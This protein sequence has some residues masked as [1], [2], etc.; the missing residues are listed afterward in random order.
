MKFVAIIPARKGSKGIKNKNFK[1]FNNKPLI[2]WTI[3]A[4]KKSNFIDKIIVST[5]SK[6]IQNFSIS[7]KVD[8]PFLRPKK[9]ST[10]TAKAKDV[11]FHAI[12]FL[13][14]K[15]DYKPD[16]VIY[17]QPTSPLREAKDID[18]C[19]KIFMKYKPDSLVSVVK[20]HHNL[21]P[22]EQ[23]QFKKNHKL[24]K[25]SKKKIGISLRQK[26]KIFYGKN[27]AAIS[28]TNIKKIKYYVD[29]G[30][31]LGY[32]MNK[33]KSIDID[34]IEDFIL[35]EIIQKKFKFNY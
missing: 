24:S 18:N 6:Q 25:F 34:E 30:N 19:C 1:R 29:G 8:C 9:I 21:N 32:K 22:N 35:A 13:R 26:K 33:L 28:I 27:G 15:N 5:D 10:D 4:A 31:I 7:Q 14:K 20:T 2:F 3:K 23:Y 11:I 17:L 12:D 16:A